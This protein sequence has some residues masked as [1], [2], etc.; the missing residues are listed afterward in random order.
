MFIL[1]LVEHVVVGLTLLAL[2]GI[3]QKA[4]LAEVFRTLILAVKQMPGV[5]VVMNYVIRSQVNNF[6]N[7][8]KLSSTHKKTSQQGKTMSLPEKGKSQAEM[9]SVLGEMQVAETNHLEGKTFAYTYTVS[10]EHYDIQKE[11]FDKF[12]EKTLYSDDHEEVVKLFQRTFLHENALNPMVYPSL[13]KMETEVVG[14]TAAMLHGDAS[15]VGFLTSGGTESVLMAVYGARNWARANWP[16]VT[17]PEIVAPSTIHP[18][19]GK[20]AFYFG[21]NIKYIPVGPDFRADVVAMEKAITKNTVLVAVSA[22]QYCH[23][24]VDPVR[25][26][27]DM[28]ARHGILCHVDACFGGFMLPWVEKLGYDVPEWDF[29][30]PGVTSISAD[31]HKYGYT[32]KGASVLV[33]SSEEIRKHQIYTY[34]G[35]PGGLYASTCMA[36]TRPGGNIAAAWSALMYLGEE[37]YL[38]RA[39]ELMDITDRLKKEIS[40]IEGLKILGTPHMTCFSVASAHPDLHILVLADLLEKK[41]WHIERNQKPDSIHCSIMPQHVHSADSFIKD[42][43]ECAK[44][45]KANQQLLKEGTAGVYGLV[46]TIPDQSIVDDFLRELFSEIYKLQ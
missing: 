12:S 6:I 18:V 19:M 15:N 14:M 29:R 3:Y 38:S 1:D 9:T 8:S 45:A 24:I 33:Y 43:A 42:I 11:A 26:V 27:S 36:G 34:A 25:E 23:G 41:G 5:G 35:W 2:Y 13:R 32:V 40:S 21:L 46:T 30:C 4:G 39:R 20:A 17:Q 22:P 16:W 44:E 28:A 10:D 37:G 7:N 31:V